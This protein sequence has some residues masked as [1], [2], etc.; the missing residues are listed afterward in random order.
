MF[1]K[2]RKH[3]R[4]NTHRK[5]IAASNVL[6]SFCTFVTIFTDTSLLLDYHGGVLLSFIRYIISL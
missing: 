4:T 3:Q 6:L 5:T 2:T 1:N